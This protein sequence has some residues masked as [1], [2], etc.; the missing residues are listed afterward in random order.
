MRGSS[1]CLARVYFFVISSGDLKTSR[2]IISLLGL[3]HVFVVFLSHHRKFG[4]LNKSLPLLKFFLNASSPPLSV[5]L[6]GESEAS[7]VLRA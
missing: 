4:K 6:R 5:E 3:G 1:Q 7:C 2:S